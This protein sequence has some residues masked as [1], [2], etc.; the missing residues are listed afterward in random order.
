[1]SPAW[2]AREV[3][4]AWTYPVV[5][6]NDRDELIGLVNVQYLGRELETWDGTCRFAF[7]NRFDTDD[8][9][10]YLVARQISGPPYVLH[11]SFKNVEVYVP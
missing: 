7:I 2:T 9:L 4:H 1:M 8:G 3:S 10:A 11:D 5:L 6:L